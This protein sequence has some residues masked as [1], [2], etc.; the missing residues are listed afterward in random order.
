MRTFLS[1]GPISSLRRPRSR[2]AESRQ[3]SHIRNRASAA[4]DGANA[5]MNTAGGAGEP[6]I[7]VCAGRADRATRN[8]RRDRQHIVELPQE[9][10]RQMVRSMS[11]D[12]KKSASGCLLSR[13]L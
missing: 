6:H 8:P 4:R 9:T 3:L 11:L 2:A 13:P 1:T 5:K 12:V 7:V 10:K